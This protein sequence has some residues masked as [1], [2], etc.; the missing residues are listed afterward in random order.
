MQEHEIRNSHREAQDVP[1]AFGGR[2]LAIPGE[3]RPPT[4][5]DLREVRQRHRQLPPRHGSFLRSYATHVLTGQ[6]AFM[7]DPSNRLAGRLKIGA[8]RVHLGSHIPPVDLTQQQQREH[9]HPQQFGQGSDS[10]F[11]RHETAFDPLGHTSRGRLQGSRHGNLFQAPFGQS[12]LEP[13]RQ[14]ISHAY[15]P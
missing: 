13:L 5:A 3:D 11:R 6:Q 9:R 2:F 15:A 1:L 8:A 14:S 10:F 7:E 12:L 4:G